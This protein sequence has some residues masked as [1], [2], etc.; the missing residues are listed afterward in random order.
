MRGMVEIIGRCATILATESTEGRRVFNWALRDGANRIP[1][2]GS[3]P[4]GIS[5]SLPQGRCTQRF[6]VTGRLREGW[7]A[8]PRRSPRR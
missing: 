6:F 2:G 8:E 1:K 7:R 3:C 5:A 4:V